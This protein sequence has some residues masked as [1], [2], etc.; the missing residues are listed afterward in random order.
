MPLI[1]GLNLSKPKASSNK[2]TKR[3]VEIGWHYRVGRSVRL[4]CD[5]FVWKAI[6]T[7]AHR[8]LIKGDCS[9]DVVAVTF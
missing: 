9:V 3:H 4:I 7:V 5:S 2:N 6:G 1:F 8:L